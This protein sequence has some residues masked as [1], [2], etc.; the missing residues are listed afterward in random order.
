MIIRVCKVGSRF[1]RRVPALLGACG[2]LACSS[3]PPA[4]CPKAQA[5]FHVAI[6]AADGPL[7]QDTALSVTYGG[8]TEDYALASPPTQPEVVYCTRLL[9]DAGA[10]DA[11]AD[12][13]TPDG[14]A[15]VVDSL[16]CDLWTQA[17]ATIQVEASG[18][19]TITENLAP[20]TN[21]CGVM[22]VEYALVLDR[23]D[24]G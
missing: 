15:L 13:A 7:P 21:D 6:T 5:A 18:Y 17:A 22:T 24:G 4:D 10:P 23:G 2:L 3:S 14:G 9:G 19:P 11:G 8:V 12:A 1:A 16:S 20:K